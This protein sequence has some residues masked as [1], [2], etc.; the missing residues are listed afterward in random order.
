M[1]HAPHHITLLCAAA[2][3]AAAFASCELETSD[4]GKFD[5]NWHL[6]RVDTIATG[7]STDLSGELRF[8]AVQK[9]LVQLSDKAHSDTKYD[10][11]FDRTT[12]SLRLYNP[13]VD[14]RPDGDPAVTDATVLAP[15]GLNSTD[16]HFAVE[17]LTGSRLTLANRKLRLWLRKL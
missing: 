17:Q 11:R 13:Y 10:L 8:W 2:M 9:S 5:G 3:T 12:D 1:K 16:E 7:G 14:Y 4:N 15:F 6:E